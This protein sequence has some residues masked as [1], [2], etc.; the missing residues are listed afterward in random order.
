M[1]NVKKYMYWEDKEKH[2]ILYIDGQPIATIYY[3]GGPFKLTSTIG[4]VSYIGDDLH[5]ENLAHAKQ[6]AEIVIWKESKRQEAELQKKLDQMQKWKTE[7]SGTC[8]RFDAD[9]VRIE[10]IEVNSDHKG[11]NC[12]IG[13]NIMGKLDK[14]FGLASEDGK[15]FNLYVNFDR[16]SEETKL[17]YTV[18]TDE[19][20]DEYEIS[21]TAKETQIL[22]EK[23]TAYFRKETKCLVKQYCQHIFK[24][25]VESWLKEDGDYAILMLNEKYPRAINRLF[26]K[27]EIPSG[28][29][30][31]L[32]DKVY[33]GRCEIDSYRPNTLERLYLAF[34]DGNRP[35]DYEGRSLS[36]SDLVV[37][38]ADGKIEFYICQSVGFMKIF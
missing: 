38:K 13:G 36:V 2:S 4:T 12:Q 37:L 6:K 10:D 8:S 31:T 14:A 3:R 28:F 5:A 26:R 16:P 9:D 15:W 21:L 11:V 33:A 7:I 17:V 22:S 20:S 18:N 34:N 29:D 35:D 25:E 19:G 27:L 32:Y 1:S 30:L 23:L 24:E